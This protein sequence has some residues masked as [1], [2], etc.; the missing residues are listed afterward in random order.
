MKY[1]YE[2]PF[3]EQWPSPRR[4]LIVNQFCYAVRGGAKTVD[5]VLEAVGA[6]AQDRFAPHGDGTPQGESQR[7]L[8]SVIDD[9]ET[10]KFAE[11]ILW[12]EGLP[13]S[14]KQKLK[15]ASG[16]DYKLAWM[17]QKPPTQKQLK[18]LEGLACH[19]IPQNMLEAS[20]LIDKYKNGDVQR[21]QQSA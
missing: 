7:I 16:Q 6:D 3:L 10:R 14:V 1:D 15:E 9:D 12:R 13:Y 4:S 17:K 19:V 11:F 21:P 8:L 2:G 20:Q 18:Y 5:E